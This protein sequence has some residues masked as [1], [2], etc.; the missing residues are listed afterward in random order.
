[1][2]Q[3]VEQAALS[4]D[5]ILGQGAQ[6]NAQAECC[7][8]VC[9]LE[10][11]ARSPHEL[12]PSDRRPAHVPTDAIRREVEINAAALIPQEHIAALVGISRKTL[13]K[14]YQRRSWPSA[15]PKAAPGGRWRCP[16]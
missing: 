11:D 2:A 6:I 1:M 3:A 16:S 9:R 4:R 12:M 7:P 10:Q 13:L 15:T 14:H 8:H 5:G